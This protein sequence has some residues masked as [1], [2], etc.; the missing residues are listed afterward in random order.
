MSSDDPAFPTFE[1]TTY[2]LSKREWVAANILNG[3]IAA[4]VAE[5]PPLKDIVELADRIL[6]KCEKVP[7][8]RL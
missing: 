6:E 5:I 8:V 3:Y 7:N 4:G 2:G 1:K